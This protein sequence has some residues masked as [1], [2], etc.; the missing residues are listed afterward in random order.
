MGVHV[1]PEPPQPPVRRTA[2]AP[3]SAQRPPTMSQRPPMRV[4]THLRVRGR[5]LRHWDAVLDA[6]D[7]RGAVIHLM[8]YAGLGPMLWGQT[9]F[10]TP[11]PPPL[12]D[13]GCGAYDS[14]IL[15]STVFTIF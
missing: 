7:A 12:F 3:G 5:F 4:Y 15:R 14:K 10:P 11:G 9:R 6:A 2:L 1:R 13:R 8:R